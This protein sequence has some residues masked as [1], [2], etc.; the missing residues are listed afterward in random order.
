MIALKPQIVVTI[1]FHNAIIPSPAN[2]GIARRA[3]SDANILK[4]LFIFESFTFYVY[5]SSLS[6]KTLDT[7]KYFKSHKKIS[8]VEKLARDNDWHVYKII[9]ESWNTKILSLENW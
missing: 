2:A 1:P 5:K 6:L 8:V 4:V 9:Q 7:K 3:R